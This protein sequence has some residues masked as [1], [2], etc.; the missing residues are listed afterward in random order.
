MGEMTLIEENRSTCEHKIVRPNT[1]VST[2]NTI[3]N[4]LGLNTELRGEMPETQHGLPHNCRPHCF[5]QHLRMHVSV[6]T[7]GNS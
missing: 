6:A 7:D 5:A 3:V 4:G 1:A 2:T